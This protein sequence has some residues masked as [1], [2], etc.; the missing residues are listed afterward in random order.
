MSFESGAG[1]T[2][3]LFPDEEDESVTE[4]TETDDDQVTKNTAT[5]DNQ[6]AENEEK[7]EID[8]IEPDS[9]NSMESKSANPEPGIPDIA[10]LDVTEE[11]M[12]RE[13]AQAIMVPSFEEEST[14]VPYAVWR[15][16]ISHG[17][18]RTTIEMRKDINEDL[19]EDVQAEIRNRTGTKPKKT[20]LR[21]HAMILG[22]TKID[23]LIE[24]GEEWGL[25]HDD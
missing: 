19:L 9:T 18:K 16:D 23:E 6:V 13:I 25:E 21:E 8:S 7:A 17:R 14:P 4:D 11:Y 3:D 10:D 5:D 15:E 2:D 20:D 24:M 1:N 22:L 12:P